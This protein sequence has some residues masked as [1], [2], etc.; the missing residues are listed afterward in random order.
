MSSSN[1]LL[2]TIGASVIAVGV[3]LGL[4]SKKKARQTRVSNSD[5]SVTAGP[6]EPTTTAPNTTEEE[7]S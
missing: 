5:T 7:T 1:S 3:A 2:Y 4:I 6:P